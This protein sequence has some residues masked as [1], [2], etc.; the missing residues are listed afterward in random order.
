MKRLKVIVTRAREQVE[1]LASRIEALGHEVVR[2]PLIE[3]EPIGR[4]SCR[5]R[6][7]GTV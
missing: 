7:Y 4:A 2:C 1:P 3:L 6:V 5:E